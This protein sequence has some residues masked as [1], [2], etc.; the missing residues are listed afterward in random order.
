MPT[1]HSITHK[2]NQAL[3]HDKTLQL[4]HLYPI[5]LSGICGGNYNCR[6]GLPVYYQL[7]YHPLSCCPLLGLRH[8]IREVRCVCVGNG[9]THDPF[10][11]KDHKVD[12]HTHPPDKYN[13]GRD[14]QLL[15]SKAHGTSVK[16][17]QE[18]RCKTQ[19]LWVILYRALHGG[20]KLGKH[21]SSGRQ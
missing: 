21:P 10:K 6:F 18:I 3:P 17:Q 2:G 14:S 1:L 11:T 4:L 19:C 15:E 16:G 7:Y 9:T 13:I 20:V 5:D 12:L 8:L